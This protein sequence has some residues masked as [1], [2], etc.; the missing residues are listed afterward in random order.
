MIDV[1]DPT[2]GVG[3]STKK[4]P[5][6]YHGYLKGFKWV[7]LMKVIKSFYGPFRGCWNFPYNVKALSHIGERKNIN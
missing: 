4:M 3:C 1:K 7:G 5:L 6:S 2:F